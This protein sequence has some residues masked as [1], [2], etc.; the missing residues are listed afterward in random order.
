M[1]IDAHLGVLADKDFTGF[2]GTVF[3]DRGVLGVLDGRGHAPKVF[4]GVIHHGEHV[5]ERQLAGRLVAP[6]GAKPGKRGAQDD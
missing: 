3:H 4:C 1:E 6:H 2:D 5:V